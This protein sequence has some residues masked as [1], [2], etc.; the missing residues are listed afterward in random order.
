M[1]PATATAVVD[2]NA[3]SRVNGLPRRPRRAGAA[4]PGGPGDDRPAAC[5][6]TRR[7]GAPRRR[8]TRPHP[9][10]FAVIP[11]RRVGQPLRRV[12]LHQARL[13]HE[14]QVIRQSKFPSRQPDTDGKLEDQEGGEH[15]HVRGLAAP[16]TLHGEDTTL[17]ERVARSGGQAVGLGPGPRVQGTLPTGRARVVRGG[18]ARRPGFPALPPRAPRTGA[19]ARGSGARS[20]R[21]PAMSGALHGVVDAGGDRPI[22]NCS[23]RQRGMLQRLTG[24]VREPRR[25][26][27]IS[28]RVAGTS[29][30][31]SAPPPRTAPCGSASCGCRTWWGSRPARRS[32]SCAN[33]R[34]SS[35]GS[36]RRRGGGGWGP[37]AVRGTITGL[38][39]AVEACVMV[40]TP[41]TV[42][43]R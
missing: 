27:P 43:S 7:R 16:L 1:P 38:A 15:T 2:E 3:K 19:F 37:R 40:R 41:A 39:G 18:A 34:T 12:T 4:G 5:R 22:R 25:N 36:G 11:A 26:A 30:G 9:G 17:V 29:G 42:G 8:A 13:R 35:I 10:R 20:W 14:G 6:P 24:R 23:R 31:R 33:W 21:D 32:F 28:A